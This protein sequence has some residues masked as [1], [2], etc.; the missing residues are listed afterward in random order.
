MFGNRISHWVLVS[1][2]AYLLGLGIIYTGR[3]RQCEVG[4]VGRAG[5][6]GPSTRLVFCVSLSLAGGLSLSLSCCLFL[7][8]G[9]R[10]L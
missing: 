7:Y 9:S 8:Q 2:A 10:F 5:P 6:M 3:L 1:G 4:A